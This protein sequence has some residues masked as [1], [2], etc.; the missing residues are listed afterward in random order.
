MTVWVFVAMLI[1]ADGSRSYSVGD[2][3]DDS[4]KCFELATSAT[5]QL[6]EAKRGW[7]MCVPRGQVEWLL[8]HNSPQ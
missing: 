2:P 1:A 3:Y 5:R 8:R 4:T 7:A 6:M